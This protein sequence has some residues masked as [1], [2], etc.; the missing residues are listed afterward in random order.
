METQ[1]VAEQSLRGF[2]SSLNKSGWHVG[3]EAWTDTNIIC[4]ETEIGRQGD[5]RE[6]RKP[7][8]GSSF[9]DAILYNAACERIQ[10]RR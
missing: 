6:R 4:G 9:M 5:A 8:V 10:V 3:V 7:E 2:F 1:D